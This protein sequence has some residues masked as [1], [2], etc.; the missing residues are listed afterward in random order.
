MIRSLTLVITRPLTI[1]DDDA[2]AE[3][4]NTEGERGRGRKDNQVTR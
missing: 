1:N 3:D 4:T 2:T